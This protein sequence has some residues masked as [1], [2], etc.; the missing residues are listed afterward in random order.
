M[1][2]EGGQM[3]ISPKKIVLRPEEPISFINAVEF[4]G[5]GM[6]LFMDLGVITPES[7]VAAAQLFK[8]N[9]NVPAPVDFHVSSRFALSIQGAMLIH[10]RLTL[11]LQQIGSINPTLIDQATPPPDKEITHNE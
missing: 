4:S 8:A 9:P 5:N 11:L 10:Q 1:A 7:A 2:L 6:E 3:A